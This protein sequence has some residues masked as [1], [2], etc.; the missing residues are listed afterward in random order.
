MKVHSAAGARAVSSKAKELAEDEE[1]QAQVKS[2][3]THD[4]QK[5]LLY[6][7][8]YI[9]LIMLQICACVVGDISEARL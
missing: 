7:L 9:T 2:G 8:D 3:I 1:F 4:W 6:Y 5:C